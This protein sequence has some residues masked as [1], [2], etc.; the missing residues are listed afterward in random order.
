MKSGIVRF[1]K[2]WIQQF[3]S[4]EKNFTTSRLTDQDVDIGVCEADVSLQQNYDVLVNACGILN[5]ELW[6]LMKL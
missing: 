4:A 2:I 1:D 3:A 5:L 6:I